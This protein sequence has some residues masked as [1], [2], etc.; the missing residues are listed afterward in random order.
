VY[1]MDEKFK[2]SKTTVYELETMSI[3]GRCMDSRKLN[4]SKAVNLLIKQGDYLLNK[5][6]LQRAEEKQKKNFSTQEANI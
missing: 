2:S 3:I 5:I 6:Q 4:F 1:A